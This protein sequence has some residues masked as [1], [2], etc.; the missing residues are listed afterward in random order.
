MFCRNI[1]YWSS[2]DTWQ[3][4]F[5]A[6]EE[7]EVSFVCVCVCVC[8]HVCVLWKKEE[9]SAK[10]VRVC[11]CVFVCVCAYKNSDIQ[12]NNRNF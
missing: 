5:P 10:S 2:D 9:K 11:V 7:A 3:V 8:M 12:E 1:D 4:Y 6:G